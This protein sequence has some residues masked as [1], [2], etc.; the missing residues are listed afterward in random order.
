MLQPDAARALGISLT[1]L[2]QVC[3]KLGVARWPYQRLNYSAPPNAS[4]DCHT[5]AASGG[6][7]SGM[8]QSA[9]PSGGAAHQSSAAAGG[10]SAAGRASRLVSGQLLLHCSSLRIL[11][12]SSEL[13]QLFAHSPFPVIGQR[14]DHILMPRSGRQTLARLREQFQ[15]LQ[16]VEVQEVLQGHVLVLKR[17]AQQVEGE[18]FACQLQPL[19]RAGEGGEEQITIQVQVSVAD[20]LW[21][22]QPMHMSAAEIQT[23]R[24]KSGQFIVDDLS[25][26]TDYPT[27]SS[28]TS[29]ASGLPDLWA[30][31]EN[32][33]RGLSAQV[34]LAPW[35]ASAPAQSSE[36]PHPSVECINLLQRLDQRSC[37]RVI[38]NCT[39]LLLVPEVQGNSL[40]VTCHVRFATP[41]DD[42][43]GK[44]PLGPIADWH[45]SQGLFLGLAGTP[46]ICNGS[47]QY[48]ASVGHVM[49]AAFWDQA[50][51]S[52]HIHVK[53]LRSE[54]SKL[55]VY[56][57]EDILVGERDGR[58][59]MDVDGTILAGLGA[60]GQEP[61]QPFHYRVCLGQVALGDHT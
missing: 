52:L 22:V 16:G 39:R 4:V 49:S 19:V 61:D 27:V 26:Q 43:Y 35:A 14:L 50:A 5:D 23:L 37:M 6:A 54:N 28:K 29:E 55:V 56:Q 41:R 20:S 46:V 42:E 57:S 47:L 13:E 21:P 18:C 8:P 40:A 17:Q 11:E 34:P 36:R 3:R 48:S 44:N 15:G 31:W 32:Q 7:A 25:S 12:L 10:G 59:V 53:R 60:N 58:T 38:Q 24:S 9:G 30:R 33:V 51:A 1:S 45:P 2:K